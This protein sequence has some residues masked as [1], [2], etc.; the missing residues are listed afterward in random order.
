M[1][2]TPLAMSFYFRPAVE[3]SQ[4]DEQAGSAWFRLANTGNGDATELR[5]EFDAFVK[6]SKISARPALEVEQKNYSNGNF[7]LVFPVLP[8]G[9]YTDISVSFEPP[10]TGDTFV[11][12]FGTVF[13]MYL[14]SGEGE[15]TIRYPTN[16]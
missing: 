15:G 9:E 11:E 13:P 5:V 3:I 4:T 8:A 2:I 14:R 16:P 1:A 6:V 10:I 7:S 12:E